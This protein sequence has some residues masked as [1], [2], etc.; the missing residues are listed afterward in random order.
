MQVKSLI[1]S[2]V[3]GCLLTSSQAVIGAS[4]GSKGNDSEGTVAVSTSVKGRMVGGI[5]SDFDMGS[6]DPSSGDSDSDSSTM[7]FCVA[8]PYEIKVSSDHATVS[9]HRL[10][11]ENSDG[12]DPHILEYTVKLKDASY[13]TVTLNP[14]TNEDNGG[15]GFATN[16]EP[17]DCAGSNA[18]ANGQQELIVTIN[19]DTLDN[20][21]GTYKDTLTITLSGI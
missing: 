19:E 15:N 1:V 8:Q 11:L 14:N 7:E 16:N 9:T 2:F 13:N 21:A 20:I 4:Q 3:S 10:K 12:D 17:K 6:L 18:E 5:E